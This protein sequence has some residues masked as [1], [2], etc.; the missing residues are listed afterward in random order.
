MGKPLDLAPGTPLPPA[1]RAL[2]A[3]AARRRQLVEMRKQEVTRR[4]QIADRAVV[5]SIGRHVRLLDREVAGLDG[6]IAGLVAAE[7]E[8]APVA[9]R[10]RTAPGVGPVVAVGLLAEPPELGQL[11]RREIAALVGVAPIADDTGKRRG[12]RHIRGGRPVPRM[13]LYIAALHASRHDAGFRAFRSRLEAE[14]K[15][16]KQVIIA[17]AR[18]LLT[19]L[20]AMLRTGT[21]YIPAPV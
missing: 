21:E 9:R 3:L 5:C 20:K 1:R 2:Q 17:V 16:F 12:P 19:V 14:G 6:R 13:L 15:K 18:K 7:Q 8:L 11:G 10:L 4:Q